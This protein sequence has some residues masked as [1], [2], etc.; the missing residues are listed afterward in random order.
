MLFRSDRAAAEMQARLDLLV[1]LGSADASIHTFHALGD[2]LVREH[3]H[4]LGLPS[5]PRVLSRAEMVVLLRD[6]VM[7]LGLDRLLV[8]ADPGRNVPALAD[9]IARAKDRGIDPASIE[10][11]ARVLDANA[12]AT[13]VD[14]ADAEADR[15]STRLNPVTLE[16]RMPSSA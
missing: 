3:A 2:R 15:K 5:D 14:A 11:A 12:A 10:A 1:P 9:A 16:S 8:L 4:E 13:G 7:E 6:R